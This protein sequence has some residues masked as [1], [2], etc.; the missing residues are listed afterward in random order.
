V[1]R[2]LFLD[3]RLNAKLADRRL[4][5]DFGAAACSGYTP[6]QVHGGLEGADRVLEGAKMLAVVG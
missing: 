6:R 4:N 3:L 2:R 1:H 5:Q